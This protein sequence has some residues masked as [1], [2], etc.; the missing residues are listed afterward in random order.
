MNIRLYH[1]FALGWVVWNVLCYRVDKISWNLLVYYYLTSRGIQTP[2]KKQGLII[3]FAN[4][5]IYYFS[6]LLHFGF[7]YAWVFWRFSNWF[8]VSKNETSFA[9]TIGNWNLDLVK[10]KA[11]IEWQT[12]CSVSTDLRDKIIFCINFNR[13]LP[14]VVSKRPIPIKISPLPMI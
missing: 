12:Q 6:D 9:L 8:K 5:K 2:S 7:M 10:V 14:N 13:L 4:V 3:S 1:A 11:P